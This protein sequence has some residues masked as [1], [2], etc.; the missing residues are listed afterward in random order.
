[1]RKRTILEIQK[2]GE[3]EKYRE[4]GREREEEK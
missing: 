1:V 4:R 2:D 3:E